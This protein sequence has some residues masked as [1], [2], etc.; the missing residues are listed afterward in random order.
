MHNGSPLA[1]RFS[2]QLL[3]L[4]REGVTASNIIVAFEAHLRNYVKLVFTSLALDTFS[5][6]QN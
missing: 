1:P 5:F 4:L 3:I 6:T 2:H